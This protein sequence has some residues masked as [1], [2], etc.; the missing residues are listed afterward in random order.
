MG[1][2]AFASAKWRPRMKDMNRAQ[3]RLSRT[4]E[5]FDRIFN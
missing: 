4:T 1:A 3:A 2:S 5:I